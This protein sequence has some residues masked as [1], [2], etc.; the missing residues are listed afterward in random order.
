VCNGLCVPSLT[1]CI[2]CGEPYRSA[3]GNTCD[4]FELNG[5]AFGPNGLSMFYDN[6]DYRC[7]RC[8]ANAAATPS[9]AIRNNERNNTAVRASPQFVDN[10]KVVTKMCAPDPCTETIC[11]ESSDSG[12]QTLSVDGKKSQ[13]TTNT[14]PTNEAVVEANS[15]DT[16]TCFVWSLPS[17][18]VQDI[19]PDG[20]GKRMKS[21]WCNLMYDKFHEAWSTCALHFNTNYIRRQK[22]LLKTGL[23]WTGYARCKVEGCVAVKFSMENIDLNN[24][25]VHVQ[26]TV[27]GVCIHVSRG[28]CK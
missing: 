2:T 8:Y 19:L 7:T 9:N 3:D 1:C 11:A 21:A 23:S 5:V 18:A 27:T 26:C 6:D 17:K 22:S 15:T 24:S 28:I 20:D 12:D 14:L 16:T 25:H 13:R 10:V 4:N